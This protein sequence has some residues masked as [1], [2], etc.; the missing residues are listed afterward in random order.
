[1]STLSRRM[2]IL[3]LTMAV[4]AFLFAQLVVSTGPG[5]RHG[6]AAAIS[7]CGLPGSPLCKAVF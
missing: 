3:T 2:T 4:F 7:N 1:M 5:L 6:Q